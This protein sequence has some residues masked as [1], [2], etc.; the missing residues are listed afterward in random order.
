MDLNRLLARLSR[1]TLV[2]GL[3]I[4]AQ[5]VGLFLLLPVYTRVLSH[6]EYG[7]F[8]LLLGLLYFGE[9]LYRAG[10]H[11]AFLTLTFHQAS[12]ED[13]QRLARTTWSLL[14]IQAAA[15]VALLLP[16]APQLSRGLTGDA[17]HAGAVRLILLYLFFFT[18]V[19]TLMCLFRSAGRPRSV[20]ALNVAQLSTT[21]ALSL[22]LVAGQRR[23]VQGAFE[24]YVLSSILFG[25]LTAFRLF[26][27]PGFGIDPA[28]RR[29]LYRLGLSYALVQLLSMVLA[30]SGRWLLLHFSTLR[31]VALYDVAYKVGTVLSYLVAPFSVAWTTGLFDVARSDKPQESFAAVF[32]YLMAVL[33]WAG[34]AL[35]LFAPEAILLLGGPTYLEAA[36]VVPLVVTAFILAGAYSFL[37]MGPALKK[38]STEMVVATLWGLGTSLAAS[39]LLIPRLGLWGAAIAALASA[40]V[41]AI[42]ML[43]ASQRC[44]PVSYPWG[45]VLRLAVLYL[46]STAVG[47]ALAGPTIG[48]AV[49]RALLLL[50]F[51]LQ[52]RALSVLGT[53]EFLSLRRLP[54]AL[55]A[56]RSEAA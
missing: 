16:L 31:E 25:L 30:Y 22:W 52:L 34:L 36:K 44:Y 4:A 41:L 1:D 43:R 9:V 15:M 50:S 14:V 33:A 5:G 53:E 47:V 29:E 18:P 39:V 26:R 56:R 27:E 19:T 28:P 7:A 24:G 45:A 8:A 54:L 42:V 46:A 49:W 11:Y 38:S 35:S 48:S 40:L 6:E 51:P 10:V 2:Y 37:N 17:G 32:K 13:R 21:L 20:V 12:E 3:G 23:G 55:L